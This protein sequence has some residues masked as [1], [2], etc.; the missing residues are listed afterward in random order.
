MSSV[1]S[2]FSFH[3]V[4]LFS[5]HYELM[6]ILF[7]SF[8]LG[9]ISRIHRSRE[10]SVMGLLSLYFGSKNNSQNTSVVHKLFL[11][12]A[13]SPWLPSSHPESFQI[14][15]DTLLSHSLLSM[16]CEWELV[17]ILIFPKY[18]GCCFFPLW[19]KTQ[20]T[21]NSFVDFFSSVKQQKRT[22]FI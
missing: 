16:W 9:K 18:S 21:G 2:S 10:N 14:K 1:F 17:K 5:Y 8:I 4:L 13:G 11:F 15:V 12:C 7:Y 3:F 6:G 20:T 19:S 22:V